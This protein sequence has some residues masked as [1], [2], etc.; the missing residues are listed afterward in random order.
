MAK[1]S[2]KNRTTTK[3]TNLHKFEIFG[4]ID[5]PT[6]LGTPWVSFPNILNRNLLFEK[7]KIKIIAP[8]K[9]AKA[10]LIQLIKNEQNQS[11]I[12]N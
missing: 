4:W 10:D 11:I 9:S 12:A 2:F 7:I 5:L 3:L 8:A 1:I 6:K